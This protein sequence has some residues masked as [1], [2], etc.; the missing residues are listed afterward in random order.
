VKNP[1][2]TPLEPHKEYKCLPRVV[3]LLP[4]TYKTRSSSRSVP[5]NTASYILSI[6]LVLLA[7]L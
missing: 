5:H 1:H 6:V 3:K 2:L 4:Y 7:I